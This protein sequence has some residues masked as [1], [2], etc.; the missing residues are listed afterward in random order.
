MTP[1]VDV[2]L[3]DVVAL[4]GSAGGI[5]ALENVLERLPGDLDAAV[6]VV[7]HLAPEHPSMLAHVLDRKSALPVR[8][9]VDGE[10]LEP[11]TVYVAPPNAHLVVS[12]EG[13]LHLERSE[14]VNYVR[15]SADSLLLSIAETYKG[16][17]LAVVLSGTGV[18]G[19]A[20]AAAVHGIGGLVLAQDEASSEHF[21]MP[22]AA[23]LAG[24]VD[25]ILALDEIG[26]AVVDFVEGRR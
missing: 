3:C 20:G 9:A 24:G 17:C 6:I 10:Q 7:L 8:E 13:R 1:A 22:G 4:V 21:G 23:I 15:P 19:A 5:R 2:R 26:P 16:R 12:A 14:P 18:D 25:E 11:R